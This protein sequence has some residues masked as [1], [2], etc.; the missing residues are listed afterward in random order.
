MDSIRRKRLQAKLRMAAVVTATYEDTKTTKKLNCCRHCNWIKFGYI[1]FVVML[2]LG[3]ALLIVGGVCSI[4]GLLILG[5]VFVVGSFVFLSVVCAPSINCGR[6]NRVNGVTN[7]ITEHVEI[8]PER[9]RVMLTRKR[10]SFLKGILASAVSQ[11]TKKRS[12]IS[13]VQ[14]FDRSWVKMVEKQQAKSSRPKSAI[15]EEPNTTVEIDNQTEANVQ[16]FQNETTDDRKVKSNVNPDLQRYPEDMVN[17]R[18]T[19]IDDPDVHVT[20]G[21]F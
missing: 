11:E 7:E 9:P 1:V 3:V 16:K 18:R 21:K 5:G 20:E 17:V 6:H 2:C 15:E 4:T 19:T 14:S 13:E 12:S 8:T 10:P